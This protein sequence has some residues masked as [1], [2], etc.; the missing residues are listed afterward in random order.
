M[1]RFP[2]AVRHL[3]ATAI[4]LATAIPAPASAINLRHVFAGSSGTYWYCDIRVQEQTR[5]YLVRARS[6]EQARQVA[7]SELQINH[8]QQIRCY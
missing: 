5:T 2:E 6:A 3:C 4:V 1:N 7:P 8:L